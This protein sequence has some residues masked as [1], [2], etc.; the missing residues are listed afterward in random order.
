MKKF[1][2]LTIIFALLGISQAWGNTAQS[3]NNSSGMSDGKIVM[4]G[5]HA[6]FY[7]AGSP[8][9]AEDGNERFSLG[10]L[11]KSSS[12]DYTLTWTVDEGCNIAVTNIAF[13]MRAYNSSALTSKDGR[14]IL[15][16]HETSV[17]TI[18]T[19]WTSISEAGT[20]S[21]GTVIT[22]KN[23]QSG[24][25]GYPFDYYIKDIVIT[26]TISPKNAPTVVKPEGATIDVTIDL[27]DKQVVNLASFFSLSANI[28]SDFALGFQTSGGVVDG[29]NF[30]A[31]EA[32]D[33]TVKA[34]VAAKADCHEAS[35]F[36]DAVTITVNHLDQTLSWVN[37]SAIKTSMEVDEEQTLGVTVSSGLAASFESDKPE[38]VTVDASG[39]LTA[40]AEGEATI[41]VSQA[42]NKQYNAAE[43]ISKKITVSKVAQALSWENEGAIK[44]NML[45]DAEQTISAVATSG[46]AVS[47]ESSDP[48]KISV[49]ENG[50]LTALALGKA[51]ITAKQLGNDKYSAAEPISKEFE[52]KSIETPHFTPNGFSEGQT[53]TIHV[54]DQLTLTVD[55]VSEGLDGDFTVTYD[56]TVLAVTRAENVITIEGLA[57]GDAIVTFHQVGSAFVEEATKSYAF[58]VRVENTLS[59]KESAYEKY[60]DEEIEDFIENVN[61]DAEVVVE[62]SDPTIARYEGGKLIIPNSDEKSFS[63]T[64]VTITVSQAA[65]ETYEAVEKE[66]A[67]T[68]KK[69]ANVIKINGEAVY[70][71]NIV[72]GATLPIA[73][74]SDNTELAL[75]PAVQES[76]ANIVKLE[77]GVAVAN[78][79]EGTAKWNVSQPEDYKYQ[80]A[81]ATFSIKVAYAAEDESKK[82]YIYESEANNSGWKCLEF[83]EKSWEPEGIAVRLWFEA[84]RTTYLSK[85]L[86]PQQR[87]NG[88]WITA[89]SNVGGSME[90]NNFKSFDKELNA[91]ATA[92][93][94]DPNGDNDDIRIRNVKV[95]V[96]GYIYAKEYVFDVV[97]GAE[98]T[99][100]LNI[101]YGVKNGGD[102]K[103]VCDNDLFS[104]G[105]DSV[106]EYTI[107]G[108][109]GKLSSSNVQVNF[110]VPEEEGVNNTIVTIYNGVYS[111]TVKI[112]ANISKV[113]PEITA[114]NVEL[115]YGANVALA[116]TVNVDTLDLNYE[117]TEGLDV[118]HIEN[119]KIFADKLGTAKIMIST[120]ATK[121]YYAAEKE[122]T[123]T[124]N[125]AAS[126]VTTAPVANELTYT[127]AE[128]V[129]IAAG[130]AEGG[131]LKYSLDGENY[132]T[133]LPTGVDALTYIVYYKVFG[134]ANHNDSEAAQLNVTIAKAASEVTTAPQAKA[135][136]YNGE[137][138]VL[139]EPGE[140]V[141]GEMQYSLDGENYSAELPTGTEAQAYVVYYKVLGDENHTDTEAKTINVT[142]GYP[143]GISGIEAG[144]KAKK[145]LRDGQIYILRDGKV[146]NINGFEVRL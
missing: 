103:V 38:V 17:G 100:L 132:S 24:L 142:I 75:E 101:Q 62:S 66:I 128:Q 32:G 16:G 54:G 133:N 94:F 146:Y 107:S 1:Y 63:E 9:D 113:T 119:G 4:H 105:P 104:F 12:N 28:P 125:K 135:L 91:N 60:V 84:E 39:K 64:L 41:T 56:N 137:A 87:V 120:A 76:G 36:T 47:Y 40:K 49:D 44:T 10:T 112:T 111:Q 11:S 98:S 124:V 57:L 33:Y 58:A 90:R 71:F 6:T 48:T 92:I 143:T 61:S 127:G 130:E 122:I 140:A 31:T 77:E 110:V 68:V 83:G 23:Y 20:Y 25:F 22:C 144:S 42:G 108:S 72:P 115:A 14:V 59:V 114:D 15:N 93:K 126:V 50:K 88:S 116:A 2:I 45:L 79:R 13:K 3:I 26:Y 96:K 86:T 30:Y 70:S 102:L 117:V 136:T 85:T 73:I 5:N 18:G 106:A 121:Q 78:Y 8:L 139:I 37:E 131:E 21:N 123:V 43:S 99:N 89:E 46:L 134:D 81:V 52:V 19:S 53:N 95:E 69:Y 7:L 118:I 67:L 82:L 35:A 141:G 29:N 34:Q 55:N 129:L 145:I 51:T 109:N 27:E 97:P 65:T 80:A 138:Q 74:T